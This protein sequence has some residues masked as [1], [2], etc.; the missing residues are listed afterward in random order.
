MFRV[1][2][3][4]EITIQKINDLRMI[5]IYELAGAQAMPGKKGCTAMA[6]YYGNNE[7]L[8]MNETDRHFAALV[9]RVYALYEEA[10]NKAAIMADDNTRAFLESGCALAH[11]PGLETFYEMERQ[12]RPYTMCEAKLSHCFVPIVS[13]LLEAFHKLLE[14]PFYVTSGETGWRGALVIKGVAAGE[15]KQFYC[16]V[17]KQDENTY[18]LPISNF[19]TPSGKMLINVKFLRDGID[20]AFQGEGV[21]LY[22]EGSIVYNKEKCLES[23]SAF[24]NG[25]QIYLDTVTH[26]NLVSNKRDTADLQLLL[27]PDRENIKAVYELPMGI[28]YYLYEKTEEKNGLTSTFSRN[29][30]LMAQGEFAE[31]RGSMLLENK[32]ANL[33]L[34]ADGIFARNIITPGQLLQTY[35]AAG[36]GMTGGEYKRKLEDQYF[37]TRRTIE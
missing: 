33:T 25:E 29:V 22:G 1:M 26:E 31:I 13:Y 20:I 35:F 18:S 27:L 14:Q 2:D 6:V 21:D 11:E 30:C 12:S 19:I 5:H 4:T 17:T 10:E 8:N 28:A 15:V 37:L 7:Q 34:R 16:K 32:T 23:F 36:E 9:N 24:H 3:T